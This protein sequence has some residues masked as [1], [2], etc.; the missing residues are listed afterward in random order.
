MRKAAIFFGFPAITLILTSC[1]SI[2][3]SFSG[4][5]ES[6]ENRQ[7]IGELAAT[8]AKAAAEAEQSGDGDAEKGL[9]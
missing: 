4:L 9:T 8:S 6:A 7:K 2:S 3:G 1:S 5:F